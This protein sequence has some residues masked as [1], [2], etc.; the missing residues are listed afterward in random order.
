MTWYEARDRIKIKMLKARKSYA[1][2]DL[3]Y[4]LVPYLCW[5]K[6]NNSVFGKSGQE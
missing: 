4:L 3:S 5:I 2:V 1:I 6:D